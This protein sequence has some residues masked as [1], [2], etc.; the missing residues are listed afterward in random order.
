MALPA[1]FLWG[2]ALAANQCEGAYQ[3]DGKG[4]SVAD[5]MTA[6]AVDTPRRITTDVEAGVYYPSHDGVDFYH[7]YKEDIALFAQMGLKV[8]RLSIAWSRIFPEGDEIEPNER[9]LAFYRSVFAE[10]KRYNIEPVV[11]LSHYEMPLGL[12]RKY[13]GWRDRRLVDFFARYCDVCFREFG[14][15]VRYWLTFNEINVAEYNPWSPTGINK[16][17]GDEGYWP[18]IYQAAYHQF[19]ASA[20]AVIRAHEIDPDLKVGCMTLA[21]IVYPKTC[22]PLD[23]KAADDF[24]NDM[25]A[26]ADVQLRGYLPSFLCKAMGRRGV[27]LVREAGDD[28]ILR[29]GTVDF[30]GF[31]YYS[32]MVQSGTEAAAE[33]T[34]GNMVSGVKNPYLETSAWGWQ[35]DPMGL[36]LTLRLLYNRYQ[37]PLFVVE[38]GLGAADEVV[39]GRVDDDYRIAYLR[40]HIAA[41]IDAV[42]EDGVDL[43]GYTP[44][45]ALDL[46]SAGTGEM[47]KRY[48]FIYAD[49]DNEGA[50]TLERIP[51]KSFF[52]Y[53]DVIASNGTNL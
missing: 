33:K 40:A 39:D 35:L 32:S 15:T 28:E 14:D 52:W 30:V 22:H 12:V 26:F 43:M 8:L 20:K 1:D 17:P 47:K 46:V 42:D 34:G 5:V 4:L 10:L 48:G 19:V 2:A 16:R 27:T 3:E 45:S 44:W 38:N 25:L 21:G 41:M 18:T 23:A 37:K 50:G 31:S 51:K 9:G 7:R 6:G 53:R 13:G 49:R 29:A 36:R 24:Q 11:T